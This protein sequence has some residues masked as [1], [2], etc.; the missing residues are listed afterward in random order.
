MNTDKTQIVR[1]SVASSGARRRR[2]ETF[3]G[4][5]S[6]FIGVH[7]RIQSLLPIVALV[8]S[9]A[10]VA[11][12]DDDPFQFLESN[13]A[14]AQAFFAEQGAKARATL[15]AIPG[16]AQLLARI[17]ALSDSGVTVSSITA[18]ASRV[19]YLK[20][21]PG[22]AHAVLCMREG[23]GGAEREILD[24]A[25]FDRGGRPA[26]IDWFVPSPD[27]RLVAYGVSPGGSEESVLRVL[28]ADSHKDLPLEIDRARFNRNLAWHPD[29]R[30]FYY[31]RYPES[32]APG[33]RLAN[34]RVYRHQ[35]GRE[36]TRDEI[37]FAP[38]V[39][40]ARDVP[41]FVRPYFHLPL[42]SR[43]AYAIA[44]DGMRREIAVH[45]TEQ[46]DLAAGHPRWRKIVGAED[47]VLAIEG[48]KDDLFLLSKR[49][50]PRHR[51]LRMKPTGDLASARVVVPQG[52]VVIQSMAL[53]RDAIYLRAMN[54][55]VDRLE[56]V[57]IGL[58][59]GVKEAQF[60]RTP[61]DN[62]IVQLE[63]D[64]R[65]PGA[66]L[67]LQGW[68]DPPSVIQVDANGN[69]KNTRLQPAA[70]V[71][72]SDMDEVRLYA[73]GHDG[74]K[75]PVTLIYRKSTRLGGDNPTLLVGYG[76]FGE[77]MLPGYDP[78]RLAW[79]ERGGVYAIAHVRGGGEYG[80]PWV[81]GGRRA[82]K[83]NTIL[84]FI[85]VAEFLVTYG[86]TSPKRLAI[87]G[88]AAGG[89]PAAGAL[90]RRPDLFAAV[91][92]R[93]PVVDLV[94]FEKMASGPAQV[95]EFGSAATAEGAEQLRLV[96][97]YHYVKDGTAYPAVMLTAGADD[98]RVEPWQPGKMA[99]RLQAASTSGKPVLLRMNEMRGAPSRAEELADIYSFLF[100]QL[101]DPQ[102]QLP[103]APAPAQPVDD[104]V[105]PPA[106]AAR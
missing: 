37:V 64:P 4:F 65:V 95:A 9:F 5:L 8:C 46:R 88:T 1:V 72:Y 55:G 47:E 99:A 86:F 57:A 31:T 30:S 17:R 27:G 24:P 53:A 81:Q 59:G 51:V 16:R 71:D 85:S 38:G 2:H 105:G 45:V 12:A 106:P 84:D 62:A 13:D 15:D 63:T 6:V 29:G 56:R 19:F 101:G 75:I 26:A 36:S 7:R 74:A 73:P 102:F 33:K 70:T 82:T 10:T 67:R 97:P 52:D 87:E 78:T 58:L 79:L 61:F 96:S 104:F 50:A 76:A 44:R 40:G 23:I 80:E 21:Q 49:N 98:P 20:Q 60:V 41:E 42:E 94:R 83:V 3:N 22:R 39:G 100:W 103:V 69:T 32:S 54:A 43:Y 92:A 91:I 34:L 90:V 89:I 48:W 14:Q 66:L 11:H 18:T 77:S 35:L 93:V 68:I 28:G 25:R